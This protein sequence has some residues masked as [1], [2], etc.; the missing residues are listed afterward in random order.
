MVLLV[1]IMILSVAIMVLSDWFSRF[2]AFRIKKTDKL[3]VLFRPV[4]FFGG[5][6]NDF[7]NNVWF[8]FTLVYGCFYYIVNAHFKG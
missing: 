8:G 7:L 6:F 4:K 3:T 2:D 5:F 1:D